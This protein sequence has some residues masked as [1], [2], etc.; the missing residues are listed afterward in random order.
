MVSVKEV[1]TKTIS[2]FEI[3]LDRTVKDIARAQRNGKKKAV[4]QDYQEGQLV[5]LCYALR[6]CGVLT[7]EQLS[8][9]CDLVVEGA[10]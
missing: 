7:E 2:W 9:L 10:F 8:D 3:V 4:I 6:A 1:R 5:G